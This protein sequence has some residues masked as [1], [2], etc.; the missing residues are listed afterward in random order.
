ML[1]LA[2]V[3]AA[4]PKAAAYKLA[5]AG[6]LHLYVTPAW[7][8]SWRWRFRWQGKEQLLTIGRYPDLTLDEAR[9]RADEA[10]AQLARG[11]D[12]RHQAEPGAPKVRAFEYVARAWFE[13]HRT[14]W[15]PTHGADVLASLERDIFPAIG[16][17][18]IEAITTP[19]VLAALR[20]LETR[21][22]LET[23]RRVRQR[24]SAVF[25]HAMIEG[26]HDRDPSAVIVN[27]LLP[28]P[29]ARPQLALVDLVEVRQLVADVDALDAPI[30]GKLAARFLMLT[31]VRMG[32]LRGARWDEIEDLDGAEPVWRVPAAR[33]K[34]KVA[35]KAEGRNDHLV[36]LAPAA[37]AVLRAAR[38]AIGGELLFGD[39]AEGAI[40]SL[41]KR[42]GYG[43]RHVPH[44]CRASF[45]TILNQH[46]PTQRVE[47]DRALGHV[48]G[49]DKEE[50]IN[51]KVEGAYNRNTY[52]P[53]RRR[54]FDAWAD[55]LA[56]TAGE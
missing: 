34:L 25:K 35:E 3:K 9:T 12:P 13:R 23:A 10:R 44:G 54:M 53:G 37:V 29:P 38:A 18:P 27:G 21:G 15:S 20:T 30:A 5:D 50:D 7:R 45:S 17:M 28:P 8:M 26:W 46:F 4:R 39:L 49:G 1:T 48:G 14:R 6:G 43:G 19:V 24:V 41:Y 47:I 33:M 11:E 55:L 56:G 52:L 40:G 42:A 22:K 51:R 36:P 16:A 2:A 31:A 32:A